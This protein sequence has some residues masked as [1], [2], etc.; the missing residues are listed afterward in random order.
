MKTV[1][2]KLHEHYKSHDEIARVFNMT[3][4]AVTLWKQKGIP[5]NRALEVEKKTRGTITAM[6]VLREAFRG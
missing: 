4:Q 1:F 2:E 5:C 6:D 3:R